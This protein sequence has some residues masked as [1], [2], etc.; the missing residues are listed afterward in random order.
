MRDQAIYNTHPH[1]K[2]I[3]EGKHAYDVDGKLVIID[4]TL[5]AAEQA[6]LELA[7]NIAQ[8]NVT[9]RAQ[10]AAADLKIIRALAEGDILR[11]DSHKLAQAALRTQL[12]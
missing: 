9:I 8:N 12:K 10:L 11:I 4:E 7:R 6:K 5:V 3:V 2:S 1:I